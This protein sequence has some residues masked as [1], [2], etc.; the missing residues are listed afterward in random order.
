[1]LMHASRGHGGACILERC[2]LR[3]HIFE[4][5][6][7][8]HKGGDA[9]DAQQCWQ[10]AA[11]DARAAGTSAWRLT[12]CW[13]CSAEEGVQAREAGHRRKPQKAGNVPCISAGAA[14]RHPVVICEIVACTQ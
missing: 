13:M 1:M 2:W 9:H 12:M 11:E 6:I 14:V 5:L 7:D 10:Q 3:A 4:R 8:C